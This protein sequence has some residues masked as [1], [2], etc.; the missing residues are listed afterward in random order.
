MQDRM[1]SRLR[2]VAWL[3]LLALSALPGCG[4]D[5]L[6]SPTAVRLRG[7]ANLYLDCAVPKNGKGPT[8]EQEF[9][10]HVRSLP[11]FIS[12]ENGVDPKSIDASF[13]S[14]RDQEPI[15]IRYGLTIKQISG[16]SAPLIAHEKTGKN[17][18]R[19]VAFANGKVALVDEAQLQ[20]LMS[21]KP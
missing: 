5:E 1:N 19:L 2:P 3:F 4:A 8:S 21:D 15:V 13:V 14:E 6:N 11:D 18:K 16:T 20:N 7:L 10:K 12:K 17:G 9:K